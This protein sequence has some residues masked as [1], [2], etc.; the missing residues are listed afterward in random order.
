MLPPPSARLGAEQPGTAAWGDSRGA[1]RGLGE[2]AH[3]PASHGLPLRMGCWHLALG[4]AICPQASRLQWVACPLGLAPPSRSTECP[5]H[6]SESP[7]EFLTGLC[8]SQTHEQG[9]P[10]GMLQARQL[11]SGPVPFLL[12]SEEEQSAPTAA[13]VLTPF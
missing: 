13:S 4:P 7:P 12:F 9:C 10:V 1:T 3:R 11:L 5:E 6:G 8:V 2:P